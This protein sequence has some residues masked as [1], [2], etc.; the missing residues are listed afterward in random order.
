MLDATRSGDESSSAGS[1]VQERYV[2]PLT[3]DVVPDER[4][5][6]ALVPTERRENREGERDEGHAETETGELCRRR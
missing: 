3:E 5:P 6:P 4:R 2:A 1:T